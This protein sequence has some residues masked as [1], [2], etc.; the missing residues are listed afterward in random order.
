[1]VFNIKMAFNMNV[2]VQDF[3]L[4][5][6]IGDA[7]ILDAKIM[8]DVI[9]MKSRDYK[10]VIQHI[11][12]FAI[13]NFN[14]VQTTTPIDLKPASTWIPLIREVVSLSAT[15]YVQKE[16]LFIGFDSKAKPKEPVPLSPETLVLQL[17]E[18]INKFLSE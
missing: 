5:M 12:N 2:T 16:F 17:N 9:G 3:D 18:A 10:K 14:Y 15:P 7:E 13:A 1:M 8:K 6:S 11:L 4:F